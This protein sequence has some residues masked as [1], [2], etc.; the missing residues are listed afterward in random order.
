MLE[1]IE[2]VEK[3]GGVIQLRV[4]YVGTGNVEIKGSVHTLHVGDVLIH[5]LNMK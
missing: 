4:G 1:R 5:L 2:S 3:S